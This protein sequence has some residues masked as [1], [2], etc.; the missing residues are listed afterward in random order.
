MEAKWPFMLIVFGLL[1]ALGF[2]I[3]TLDK[4]S[5]MKNW[6]SRRCELPIITAAS[7][8]KPDSDPRTSSAFAKDNFNFCM[9][10]FVQSFLAL[11]MTPINALFSK[12]VG[13]T[14][15]AMEIVGTVRTLAQRMYNALLSYLDKYFR[16]FK[17]SIFEM[18]RIVQYLRMAVNRANAMAVSMLYSG[19]AMFRGI[20]NTIQFIIKVILTVCTIMLVIIILLFF[21]LFPV[22]PIIMSTLGAIIAT[23][24]GLSMV[25]SSDIAGDA[26]KKKSGFCF[27]EYTPILVKRDNSIHTVTVKDIKIGDELA[28][29]CGKVTAVIKMDGRGIQLYE[30]DGM[31]LSGTHLVKGLDGIWKSVANDI[32]SVKTTNESPILYCFNTTSNNIPLDSRVNGNPSVLLCRDWEEIGNDDE[33]GQY[34]WNFLIS[35]KLNKNKIYTSWKDNLKPAVNVAV[36]SGD[37]LVKTSEGFKPITEIG[38]LSNVLDRYGNLQCVKG[39][40]SAEVVTSTNVHRTWRSEMYELEDDAVWIKG[41]STVPVSRRNKNNKGYTLITENGDFILWDAQN[42]KEICVRDFTEIGYQCIHE[43]YSFV[44]S[45]L[46]ITEYLNSTK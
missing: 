42:K 15:I 7:F 16:S 12:H 20:I 39:V 31:Y 37:T 23:V 28:H 40:V 27:A 43:T 17:T 9:T 4:T 11:I 30:L 32:R 41:T 45:R 21:I 3:A 14:N 34:L 19:M 35:Q 33:K 8:F 18:S 22:I 29:D 44:E 26:N 36:V 5:V 46:R 10:T 24:I 2:T 6:N 25:M 1:V 13:A 38:L